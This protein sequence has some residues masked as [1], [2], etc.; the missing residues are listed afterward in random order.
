MFGN[1][2]RTISNWVKKVDE[3]GDLNSLCTK[4]RSGRLPELNVQQTQETRQALCEPPEKKRSYDKYL[5][6][7]KS[8]VVY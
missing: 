5:E 3:T 7:K 6:R 2:P 4:P 1:P 8:F